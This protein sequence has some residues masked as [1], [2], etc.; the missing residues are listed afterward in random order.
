MARIAPPTN[1]TGQPLINSNKPRLQKFPIPIYC[2]PY[3]QAF[4]SVYDAILKFSSHPLHILCSSIK[5][6]FL[7]LDL[8]CSLLLP[9]FQEM[10][11]VLCTIL[12]F[13]FL[14]RQHYLFFLFQFRHHFLPSFFL[15]PSLSEFINKKN[16]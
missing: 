3:N 14:P 6:N 9:D 8:S 2:S 4:V 16:E 13:S 15:S 7:P 10:L 11:C 12:L 1:I 5:H